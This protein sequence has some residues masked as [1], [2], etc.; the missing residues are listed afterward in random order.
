VGRLTA[1]GIGV[2]IAGALALTRS[3]SSLL[4]G[5]SAAD[6]VIYA[7]VSMLLAAVTLVAVAVPASRATRIDPLEALRDY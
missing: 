6:P 7:S 5:I 2:G 1:A 4:F 3:M